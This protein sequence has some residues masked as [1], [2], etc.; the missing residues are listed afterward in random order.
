M[1]AGS[2]AG[3]LNGLLV[4]RLKLNSFIVTLATS[5]IFYGFALILTSAA[6]VPF[7][8]DEIQTYFGSNRLF[9]L[10]AAAARAHARRLCGDVGA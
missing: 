1:L 7:V 9:G 2:I 8:P 10:R 5:G 3:L 4:T 6:N